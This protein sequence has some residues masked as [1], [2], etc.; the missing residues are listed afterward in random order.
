MKTTPSPSTNQTNGQVSDKPLSIRDQ[1]IARLKVVNC[2]PSPPKVIDFL[3]TKVQ[4][5]VAKK[6]ATVVEDTIKGLSSV[7]GAMTELEKSLHEQKG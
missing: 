6:T 5:K 1:V 4:D 2:W 7:A 3:T